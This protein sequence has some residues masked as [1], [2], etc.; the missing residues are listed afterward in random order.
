MEA[1]DDINIVPFVTHY[2]DITF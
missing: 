2:V 1:T